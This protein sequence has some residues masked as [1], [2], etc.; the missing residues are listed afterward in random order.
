MEAATRVVER[1]RAYARSGTGRF[2]IFGSFVA[3]RLRYDS[4]LDVLIDF[5]ASDSA[6]AWEFVE[7][8]CARA[9][10]EPDIHDASTSKPAF[11]A[12]V[13]ASGIVLP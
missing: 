13:I 7:D 3:R 10:I 6:A 1:L 2:V 12:R 9:R 4:D 11:V 8:A 5:P